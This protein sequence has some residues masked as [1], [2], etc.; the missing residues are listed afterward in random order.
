MARRPNVYEI[1]ALPIAALPLTGRSW[2]V[3]RSE[4][5]TIGSL[6]TERKTSQNVRTFC[7]S[8]LYDRG[9]MQTSEWRSTRSRGGEKVYARKI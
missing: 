1:A 5:P 6:S 4:F 2:R 7:L 9:C 3:L 8:Q